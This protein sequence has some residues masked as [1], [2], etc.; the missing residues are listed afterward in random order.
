VLFLN[1]QA[2]D[3]IDRQQ[4]EHSKI[5]SI[6]VLMVFWKDGKEQSNVVN[7]ME[8]DNKTIAMHTIKINQL[9]QDIK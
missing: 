7:N 4:L 8:A 2:P 1:L 5:L 6:P 9:K 3:G